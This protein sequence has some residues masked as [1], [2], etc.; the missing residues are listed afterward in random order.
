MKTIS[1]YTLLLGFM[2]T[3]C[4]TAMAQSPYV[5]N[6]RVLRD[7]AKLSSIELNCGEVCVRVDQDGKLNLDMPQRGEFEYFTRADGEY[8]QGKLKLC[9][10]TTF[11]YYDVFDGEDKRGKLKLLN[12][13]AVN[14]YDR[15]DGFD[16]IGKV[17]TIGNTGFKYYDRFD[18]QQGNTGRLKAIGDSKIAYYTQF[19]G[20]DNIG[21]LK[22]IGNTTIAYFD[23][24]DGKENLGR[25]KYIKGETPG[26]NIMRSE[27]RPRIR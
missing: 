16:N 6:L 25:I 17:K 7:E 21:K 26:L 24:F 5:I 1:K 12:G 22:M 14:Y 23:R 20:F 18:G 10:N 8:K 2:L 11:D 4:F 9:G 3:A 27:G 19:D 15:F 13:V